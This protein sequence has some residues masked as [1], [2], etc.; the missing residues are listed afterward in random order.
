MINDHE[1]RQSDFGRQ[2]TN[3]STATIIAGL[4][5]GFVLQFS[6]AVHAALAPHA[7]ALGKEFEKIA[8]R[9]SPAVV[10]ITTVR[11][12]ESGGGLGPLER[13]FGQQLPEGFGF[14]A[15]ER[16]FRRRGLGSGVI[17]SADGYILTNSHV[18]A[19]AEKLTVTLQDERQF[20]AEVVGTDPP[21]DLAVLKIE[22]EDLP[23]AALGDSEQL[24]TGA[25]VI[26]IGSPFGLAHTVTIGNV[27]AKGRANVGIAEYE[28]FIQTDAAINPGNSGGPLVNMQGQVVGINTAIFSRTGGSL[29]IG[30]AVPSTMA[31][32]VM[33][34]I[35]EKGHVTRGWLGVSIQD[36]TPQLAEALGIE[37][38]HG[39]LVADVLP[40]TPAAEAGIK[41]GD[42]I[43]KLNGDKVEDTRDLRREVAAVAPGTKVTVTVA[44]DGE[45]KQL[46]VSVGERPSREQAQPE[47]QKKLGISVR[48][49]TDTLRR[50]LNIEA[51]EGV[52]VEAVA[53]NSQAYSKGIRP[54]MVIR[55]VNREPVNSVKE[56][57]QAVQRSME[58][59]KVLFLVSAQGR[60]SYVVIPLQKD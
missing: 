37:R 48:K 29:G 38:E 16:Q 51:E 2:R 49:L 25:F 41:R 55:E 12:V 42:I 17:V 20:E 34:A 26:A 1:N 53:P 32:Y 46:D 9:V 15:P 56:F 19:E 28:D 14:N 52:V 5:L 22:N 44:R 40:D 57:R 35:R 24:A 45:E 27:S 3:V 47:V 39:A 60:T 23:T 18:V 11:V 21:T 50:R 31:E 7:T 33:Q 59:G 36:V 54:G 10:S 8:A 6:P 30:F 43:Y 4:F 58:K 13:F